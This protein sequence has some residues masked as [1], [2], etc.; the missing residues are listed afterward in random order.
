MSKLLKLPDELLYSSAEVWVF[1]T[2]RGNI[3]VGVTKYLIR[4]LEEIVTVELPDAG[5][6]FKK[7]QELCQL[8][9]F[10]NSRGIKCPVGGVVVSINNRLISDPD[11]IVKKP[12]VTWLVELKPDANAR[13]DKLLD[14][15][16][17]FDEVAE[18]FTSDSLEGS[19]SVVDDDAVEDDDDARDANPL[20]NLTKGYDPYDDYGFEPAADDED[21]VW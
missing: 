2:M 7:G 13:L 5:K 18:E 20:D 17:V 4:K 12:Y 19:S 15:D 3:R 14:A 16:Q 21:V 11:L 8:E 6:R 1:E 9:S 10:Q